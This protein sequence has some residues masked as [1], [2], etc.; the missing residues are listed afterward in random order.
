MQSLHKFTKLP[1]FH[2]QVTVR[3]LALTSLNYGARKKRAAC[4]L[5]EPTLNVPSVTHL[6]GSTHNTGKGRRRRG[7]RR[8]RLTYLYMISVDVVT[9]WDVVVQRQDNAGLIVCVRVK[10]TQNNV[11]LIG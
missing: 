11:R 10:G 2:Q 7:R 6:L 5:P 1:Q 9:V 3:H 8:G 4:K